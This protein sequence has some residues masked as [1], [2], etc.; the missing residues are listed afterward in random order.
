[1]AIHPK[2]KRIITWAVYTLFLLMLA[3]GGARFFW[4]VRGASFLSAHRT[5]HR[6]FYPRLAHVERLLADRKTSHLNV[7]LLGGSVLHSDYGNV[8]HLLRERLSRA[9]KRHVRIHNLAEPGHTSLDS[10]YKYRRLETHPF[11][12]VIVYHG[13]NEMRAN[14]CPATLFREDYSHLSWYRLINDWERRA[15]DRRLAAPYTIKFVALKLADRLGWSGTLPTHRPDADSLVYGC[16]VKTAGPFQANL[17]GILTLAEV[18]QDPVLLMTFADYFPANYTEEAFAARRL[19]YTSHAFP[20]E[21]WGKP[22]CTGAVLAAHNEAVVELAGEHDSVGFVDQQRL[23]PKDGLYFNDLCHL[24][25]EGCERFVE[26]L[27]KTALELLSQRLN[28]DLGDAHDLLDG[29]HALGHLGP[30]VVAHQ[31]KPLLSPNLQ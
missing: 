1:M 16:E 9:T 14:N 7:L 31:L 12:L 8:E 2:L 23:V 4:T 11:D 17:K 21:L 18:K 22:E 28:I 5:I 25:H 20:V 19:D 30:S 29:G 13:I 3:E 6:S 15:N 26:N 10:L 24:T 27:M